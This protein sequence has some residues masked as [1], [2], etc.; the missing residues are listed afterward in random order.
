MEA[1]IWFVL[2]LAG[3]TTAVSTVGFF[4]FIGYCVGQLGLL[5]YRKLIHGKAPNLRESPS[6]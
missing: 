5:L 3:F 2:G 1:V 4:L 6:L